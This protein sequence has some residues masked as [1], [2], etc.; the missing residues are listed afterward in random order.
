MKLTID[1]KNCLKH[2]LTLDEVLVALVYRQVKNPEEVYENLINR[3][4][5]VQKEDKVMVTQRWSDVLDDIICD[6]TG[7]VTYSD[8]DLLGLAKKMQDAYHKGKMQDNVH[9]YQSNPREISSKLKKFFVTYGN[10]S[11][12]DII[13]ATKRY[14]ASFRG[15]YKYMTALNNFVWK[16]DKEEDEDGNRHNVRHSYLA[17]YLDNKEDNENMVEIEDWTTKMI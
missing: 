10:Y 1:E 17:D 15:N 5:L 14:V 7:K 9:Y 13:D 4:V 3:E 16:M 2:K 12:D 6:S 11:E 8:I